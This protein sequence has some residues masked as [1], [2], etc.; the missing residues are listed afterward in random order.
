MVMRLFPNFSQARATGTENVIGYKQ[1]GRW[2]ILVTMPVALLGMYDPHMAVWIRVRI[3]PGAVKSLSIC[4]RARFI[5][6]VTMK[7]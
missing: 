4:C 5:L 3:W 6:C 7:Q 2:H 1:S